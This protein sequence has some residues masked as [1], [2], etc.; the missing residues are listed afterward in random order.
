[1]FF[2]DK[3]GKEVQL[4]S[5]TVK[6]ISKHI[7]LKE[8]LHLIENTIKYPEITST[9]DE[10]ENIKYLQKFLKNEEL[11]LIIVIKINQNFD[12]IITIYKSKKPKL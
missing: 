9:D 2:I 3:K 12:K 4:N 11:Y 5:E 10:R 6:H 1:M 8:N 7:N